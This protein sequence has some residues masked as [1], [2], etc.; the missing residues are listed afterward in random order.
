[1]VKAVYDELAKPS[2]K[3]HFTIGI[4]DDVG[5]TSLAFDPSFDIEPDDVVRA[6]FFGLGS[7]GTVGANK[8]SIKIIADDP[9]VYA[10]AYFVYDSKKSGSQT[11]SHLRFG[12]RPIHS[13]YLIQ[14]ASFIGCHQFGFLERFDLLRFAA[15]GATLLVDTSHGRDAVWSALPDEVQKAIVDK[16]VSLW[17]IDAAQGGARRRAW[18][19]APNVI[20][21]TCFFAISGVLPREKAH[22][23]DPR[24]DR[25]DLRHQGR[26]GGPEELRRRRSARCR[27]SSRSRCP[28]ASRRSDGGSRSSRAQAPGVRPR[29]DRADDGGSRRRDPGERAPGRRH[30]RERHDE[31]GEAQRLAARAGVGAGALHPVRKLLVRVPA[32]A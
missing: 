4:H 20:M 21:Q 7:D 31:V 26:R 13:S 8:N 6:M 32:L 11:T 25:E 24:V 10:Q 18:A 2:P 17:V 19:R 9:D 15:R 22:R 23:E 29:G 12:P 5:H 3:N 16:H 1:M 28:I 27:S 14:S 30:V